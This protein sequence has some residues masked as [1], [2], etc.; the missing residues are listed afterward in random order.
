MSVNLEGLMLIGMALNILGATCLVTPVIT[1]KDWDKITQ[2]E[3]ED[4][5]KKKN[6]KALVSWISTVIGYLLLMTGFIFQFLSL[7]WKL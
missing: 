2:V 7:T 1:R 5:I 6:R 4:T 3:S